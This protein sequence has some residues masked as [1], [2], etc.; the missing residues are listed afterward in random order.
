MGQI[1]NFTHET[2]I[3]FASYSEVY[4]GK[5]ISTLCA[6]R[7]KAECF[8]T[9]MHCP[10]NWYR[11]SNLSG[12]MSVNEFSATPPQ[13]RGVAPWGDQLPGCPGKRPRPPSATLPE[14]TFLGFSHHDS[15]DKM[16]RIWKSRRNWINVHPDIG[17]LERRPLF[18]LHLQLLKC[19]PLDCA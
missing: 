18:I 19:T 5:W 10:K 8:K 12:P 7:F 13:V 9:W 16:A 2:F 3:K 15:R 1:S 11:A 6:L 17:K 4:S 14:S